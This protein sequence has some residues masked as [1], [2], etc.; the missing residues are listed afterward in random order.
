M[1]N[2]LRLI[3]ILCIF[4]LTSCSYAFGEIPEKYF[5]KWTISIDEQGG[6]PWWQQ[7]KYPSTLLVSES[8][9]KFVDDSGYS[10]ASE[11][12]LYDEDIDVLVFKHCLPSKSQ[13]AYDVFYRIEVKGGVIVGET[14]TYKP[15]FR[16]A[17]IKEDLD[18]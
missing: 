18:S 2:L 16:W 7:V 8:G 14:W 12:L 15:L 17:G 6:F 3:L 9:A 13:L 5:G 1:I 10:C 4:G 11:S